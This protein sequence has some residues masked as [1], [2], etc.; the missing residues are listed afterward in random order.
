MN[1]DKD[2]QLIKKRF[3]ELANTASN[4][5]ILTSTDFLNLNEQNLF[6]SI[7]N[8]LPIINYRFFGGF[9]NSERKILCFYNED[10]EFPISCINI[11]PKNVKFSNKLTHRDYLGA[12]INLGI[13]RSKLGDIVITDHNA[14]VFC[15][16]QIKDYIIEN[17]YQVKNTNIISESYNVEEFTYNPKFKEI[18]GT[19]SSIRL[20]SILSVAFNISRNKL[21][22]YILAGKVFV[23]SKVV[24][25]N[26]YSLKENDIV[27]VRG[28]GKFS[29]IG[30]SYKTKK[31]RQSIKI[32]LYT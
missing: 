11:K 16:D 21:T 31:G 32:H 8:E 18:T 2:E 5:Y 13:D 24:I 3:I 7:L 22:D 26:N 27:S 28:L 20:D 1:F 6:Y 14:Y 17:L 9:I 23:N 25:S 29:F 12:I 30:I 19:V 15:H 10:C 4:K